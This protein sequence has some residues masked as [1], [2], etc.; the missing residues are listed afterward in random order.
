MIIEYRRPDSIEDALKLLGRSEPVTLPLGG[1]SFLN[2]P[3]EDEFAV[4]DLQSL[5][6]DKI[7]EKGNKVQIGAAAT[8]QALLNFPNSDPAL[9]KVIRHEAT[10]N[11]RQVA[12]VAGALVAA[13]GR[14]PFA[15][16]ML[17]LSAQLLLL[18]GDEDISLGDLLPLGHKKLKSRLITQIVIPTN[19]K[20]AYEYVAR[21]PADLP[22]V[23]VCVVQW[24]SGRTRVA[25]GGY[26]KS[27]MLAMDGPQPDGAEIAARDA[28]SEVGDHWASAEYRSD[29]AAILT[30]RALQAIDNA[31]VL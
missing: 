31:G 16:A 2:R 21:S 5:G 27:S 30:K 12:T 1:G 18:P 3:S 11:I 13:D 19:V 29:V 24:P 23:C 9:I 4:V 28:Y 14:S 7:E 10:Y 22:I 25:L 26:G 15:T 20:I 6:L 8:L 17:A